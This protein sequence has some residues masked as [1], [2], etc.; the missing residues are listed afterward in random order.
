[1]SPLSSLH[2]N[3]RTLVVAL[4]LVGL[5]CVPGERRSDA[6]PLPPNLLLIV[7][8]DVGRDRVGIYEVV[9]D[10]GRTPNIDRLGATGLVFE[11]FWSM[12][13]CSPT[14]AALITGLYPHRNGIGA[15]VDPDSQRRGANRGLST[16]L[17]SLPRALAA[18]GYTSVIVGKWHLGSNEQGTD[19]ALQLGFA[20]H[21]GSFGNLGYRG[22]RPSYTRWTK[23]VDGVRQ[24]STVYATTDTVNDA[25]A[26]GEGLPEPWLIV[27]SFNAAH[28]PL[29]VPPSDLHGFTGLRRPS[30]QKDL[31]RRAMIEAMDTEIG[32]LTEALDE[33]RPVIVFMGDNG[34]A[35]R[36]K[37]TL[38]ESGV[39]VP[40]IVNAPSVVEPGRRVRGLAGVTDLFATFVE[41]AGI[42]QPSSELPADS[43]SL[44]PYLRSADPSAPREWLFAERFTPNGPG[45]Y[46][47]HHRAVRGP[48]YKL[49]W[50]SRG[51]VRFHDLELDP[52]ERRPLRLAGLEG[53]AAIS[54][55]RLSKLVAE[56]PPIRAEAFSRAPAGR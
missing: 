54:Y 11:N 18:A 56:A 40:L 37:G 1:V 30:E 10:P 20:H 35:D 12:P 2:R 19:H 24:R 51:G 43:V 4:L 14:R 27:V 33:R 28:V 22:E 31:A 49:V 46:N 17:D 25:I 13:L 23:V 32:R 55:R 50:N 38:R 47:R 45:P 39:R 9:K 6:A 52:G 44:V 5:G 34:T 16:E 36:G 15:V 7:A 21:F 3:L 48:R 26:F 29:H 42:V 41:L 53:D 8:D